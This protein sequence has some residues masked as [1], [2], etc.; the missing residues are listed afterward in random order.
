M[1]KAAQPTRDEV[2]MRRLNTPS[3]PFTPKTMKKPSPGG[4]KAKKPEE[5]APA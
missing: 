5:K 2:V 4:A 1:P 3:T